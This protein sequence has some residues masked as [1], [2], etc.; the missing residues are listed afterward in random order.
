MSTITVSKD[1]I[2]VEAFEVAILM[3]LLNQNG[4]LQTDWFSNPATQLVAAPGRAKA[5][6]ETL[7]TFLG[8]QSSTNAPVFTGAEWYEI[9]NP[10]TG[11]ATGFYVVTPPAADAGGLVGLG[12]QHAIT[13]G[14][15][16]IVFYAFI[17]VFQI[18]NGS[19]P[20][21][22]LINSTPAKVS[23]IRIGLDMSSTATLDAGSAGTFTDFKVEAD[24]SL[25]GSVSDL[26][27]LTIAFT[28]G[29]MTAADTY[30]SLTD[31]VNAATTEDRMATLIVQGMSYWLNLYVGSSGH[32]VGDVLVNANLMG[33]G[34]SGKFTYYQYD[35]AALK[36]IKTNPLGAA[37]DILFAVLE[38]LADNEAPLI[39]LPFLNPKPE[40]S[41]TDAGEKAEAGDDDSD[42]PVAGVWVAFNPADEAGGNNHGTYGL[43]IMIPDI[44]IKLGGGE[45][46]P[47]L[48]LRLGS[49]FTGE[50]SDETGWVNAII[51][52]DT[53]LKPGLSVFFLNYDGT[54]ISFAP[55]FELTSAGFDLVGAKD[56]PLFDVGG[57]TMQGVEL[58]AYVN[59]NASWQYG[60]GAR[61]DEVGIP[62]GAGFTGGMTS[63]GGNPVAKS[64]LS[65]GDNSSG[66][67]AAQGKTDAVNPQFSLET[68]YVSG[69]VGAEENWFVELLP[70]NGAS[71][72]IV[73]F[74]ISRKFGPVSCEKV[75]LGWNQ[76]NLLLDIVVDGGLSVGGLSAEL[77]ELSV[78]IPLNDPTSITSYELGLKGLDVSYTGGGVEIQGG[79]VKSGSGDTVEYDGLASIK[80]GDFGIGAL[81]SYASLP[82]GG[83]SM[84]IFAF[85]DAPLGGPAAFFVTGLAAGFGYNRS[86]IPPAF[87]KVADFPLVKGMQDPSALGLTP[88]Q[89][90]NLSSVLSTL[91]DAVPPTRGQYWL[92]AGVKFTSFELIKSNVLLAVEFGNEF[93]ILILGTSV[94]KL[95]QGTGVTMAYA[96]LEIEVLIEPDAGV[97]EA[98]AVLSANSYVLDP[99]CHLTGGF[100]FFIWF[101]PNE[102]AGDFVLTI[103]GYHPAFKKPDWYP[104]IPR[105]GFN[106]KISD[107]IEISGGAYFALTPSCIMAGGSLNL[108]FSAGPINAWF[109]A[110]ADMLIS[111]KPFFYDISIGVTIGVS[112]KVDFLFIKGTIK[113]EV[114]A[115]VEIWGPP[116]GGKAHVH[117]WVVSFT[118]AFGPDKSSVNTLTDWDGFKQLLPGG[119]SS[120]GGGENMMFAASRMHGAVHGNV[121]DAGNTGDPVVCQIS[122]G[123]GVTSTLTNDQNEK[124]WVVSPSEFSFNIS[125]TTPVTDATLNTK[126]IELNKADGYYVGARPMGISDLQ[127][128][129]TVTISGD[130]DADWEYTVKKGDVPEAMWG[131]ALPPGSTPPASSTL[132]L[133]RV[134][135]LTNIVPEAHTPEGPPV[136]DMDTAFTDVPVTQYPEQLP[137]AH[138]PLVQGAVP[139]QGV[140]SFSQL[141]Q[142]MSPTVSAQRAALFAAFDMLG[143]FAGTNGGLSTMAGDPYYAYCDAPMTGSP[144]PA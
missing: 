17:P 63:G 119:G 59:Q 73:W 48:H 3:G 46:S 106:W 90:P 134:T 2:G 101:G 89:A 14:N 144:L 109:N 123:S 76:A 104:D 120:S 102:H 29:T 38:A 98:S 77:I 79:F 37:E 105:L 36:R 12:I 7:Q 24:I 95:P 20:D 122:Y 51:K 40:A 92:A 56:T 83:T 23:P 99:A 100:A 53:P 127:T 142:I 10:S 136:I 8:P 74:P 137:F 27:A 16:S 87:D 31:F 75:G 45:T 112:V 124:V 25:D 111:W 118:I 64:L 113:V 68:A 32:T 107:E 67:D 1:Q 52:G 69:T 49:W 94:L 81:G 80:V 28:G 117:L 72:D 116:T 131:R 133:D 114:G 19:N 85:L 66:G 70:P 58:R 33:T 97:V 96:E 139:T 42:G 135:G 4:D 57:V 132:L 115:D 126:T 138:I 26:F 140:D 84:F 130:L 39:P 35:A 44:P 50:D 108:L 143:V 91:K 121:A 22:V 141:K 61:L 9:Q 82:G 60:F 30:H 6:I 71:G 11:A 62:L 88:G 125:T 129:L 21:F 93:E 128:P 43:R 47:T 13:V 65:S 5:L 15:L 54:N 55:T 18:N 86:L 78:G 110:N 103:G 34:T 41:G